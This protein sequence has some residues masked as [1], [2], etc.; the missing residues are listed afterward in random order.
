MKAHKET[1]PSS[2]LSRKKKKKVTNI[3][4][5]QKTNDFFKHIKTFSFSSLIRRNYEM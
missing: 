2:T 4:S 5:E 3:N 1:R